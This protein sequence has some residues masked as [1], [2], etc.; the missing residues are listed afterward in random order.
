MVENDRTTVLVIFVNMI[1]ISDTLIARTA[2]EKNPDPRKM[3]DTAANLKFISP[4]DKF[5][6]S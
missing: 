6:P 1:Q 3:K 5:S 4:A 2:G